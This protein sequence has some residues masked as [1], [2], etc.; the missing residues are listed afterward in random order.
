VAVWERSPGDAQISTSRAKFDITL[1]VRNRDRDIPLGTRVG[2]CRPHW[3]SESTTDK[4]T[5]H[6][7]RLCG[8]SRRSAREWI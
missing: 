5:E 7:S 3:Q 8:K 4:P 6:L 1:D 2:A